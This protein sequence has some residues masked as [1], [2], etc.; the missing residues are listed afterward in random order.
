[1]LWLN[2]FRVQ[3]KVSAIHSSWEI[4]VQWKLDY[5]RDCW[6]VPRTYCRVHDEP[7][8]LNKMI[9]RTHEGI[10]L[11]PTDIFQGSM[12]F[13]CPKTGQNLKQS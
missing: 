9:A 7:L 11:G 3:S 6:V 4:L 12:K 8:A 2:A 5:K 10:A 1:V 13:F